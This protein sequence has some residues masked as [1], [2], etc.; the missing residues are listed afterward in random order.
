MKNYLLG[1]GTSNISKIGILIGTARL[2]LRIMLCIAATIEIHT[3]SEKSDGVF[4]FIV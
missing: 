3:P 4:V 2:L 1:I